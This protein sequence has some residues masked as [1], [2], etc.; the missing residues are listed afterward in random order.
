MSRGKREGQWDVLRRCLAII[1]RVQRGPARR[2]DLIQAVLAQ[3]GA[4]AYG[5][6]EG[7]ALHRRL[8]NDLSRIRDRLQIDLYY[9]RQEGGYIIRDTW[10]PLLD[11]PNEDLAT[12]AW[13]EETFAADSP[14]H[15]EIHALTSRLRLFLGVER[16]AAIV[17][18]RDILSVDL[19]QRDEDRID[20]QVWERLEKALRERRRV[21]MLYLSPQYED[22][23]PRRHVVEPHRCYFDAAHGHYYLRGYCR[24]VEG[25]GERREAGGYV[26]YR[27]G[28]ILELRV[29]PQK[30]S[31]LT[32][33]VSRY[34]VEYELSAQVA[35]RGVSRVPEI[36]G[37]EIEQRDDGSAVVRG[38]TS[39]LFWAV[40][41]LLHYG[42]NCRVL[43]GPEM[44]A[45]MRGTVEK[46]ARVYVMEYPHGCGDRSVVE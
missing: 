13:L 1:R 10:L 12:I 44:L 21:E 26:T 41:A 16:Q 37:Q 42:P 24:G 40:Q 31:P 22:G 34:A 9:S 18:R 11:L 35:R 32:P 28:R 5:T 15:D 23:R 17:C 30:L 33:A 3:E 43:G 38:E 45:E 29:L 46:M 4:E 7:K 8:E 6:A 19:R 39:S 20:A 36:E 25:A 14:Y 2:G 27:V